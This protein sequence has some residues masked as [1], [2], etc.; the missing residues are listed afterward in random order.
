MDLRIAE[1]RPSALATYASLPSVLVVREVF[2]VIAASHGI[3]GLRLVHR[4]LP[5]P[6]T[7]DYDAHPDYHP[8]RWAERFDVSSW[9][10]LTAWRGEEAVGKGA[11]AWNPGGVDLLEGRS[12]LAVLWDIRVLRTAQ[13]MGAGTALFRA[14]EAWAKARGARWLKV[15]TQN[16]NVPACHFYEEMGCELG[17]IDRFAYPGLPDETQLIWYKEL[18]VE[19]PEQ[20]A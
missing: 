19:A 1:D 7:K 6:Y 18:D 9:G 13:R 8:A 20:K 4:T 16:I 2:D 10:F 11:I 15:E 14:A 17:A 12:D 3:D 5:Q